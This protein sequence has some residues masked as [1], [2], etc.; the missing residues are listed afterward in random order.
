LLTRA[1]SVAAVLVTFPC[2]VAASDSVPVPRKPAA[3]E[4]ER[5]PAKEI[6]ATRSP[7]KGRSGNV[8]W[9]VV[10]AIQTRL[11]EETA[12]RWDFVVSLRTTGTGEIRLTRFEAGRGPTV[13]NQATINAPL[14]PGEDVRMVHRERA[15][16]DEERHEAFRR[17]IGRN[18][19]GN[20]VTIEV[21]IPFDQK[22]GARR[23]PAPAALVAAPPGDA[24]LPP[25]LR[26]IRPGAGVPA[27]WA[28]FS[29]VW[30]GQFDGG[31]ATVL[32][33]EEVGAR[34]ATVAYGIGPFRDRPGRW[35]RLKARPRRDQLVLHTAY[36][37][38][39]AYTR[40]GDGAL[41][42]TWT[43]EDGRSARGRLTRYTGG[44]AQP[45]DSPLA[46]AAQLTSAALA[47]LHDG[48]LADALPKAQEALAIREARL[49]GS[50]PD[51]AVSLTTLAEV[52]RA[53]G[54]LDDAE[55]LHQRA[56]SIRE[57]QL[58]REHPEVAASLNHLAVIQN[59]RGK[60]KD[61]EALLARALTV[62]DKSPAGAARA[63]RV[64]VDVL[65]TLAKVYRAQGRKR[66]AEETQARATMLWATQ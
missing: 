24:L 12:V 42:V 63:N 45:D 11:A 4:G 27:E 55:R 39:A 20:P 56:L 57:A 10:D 22:L 15:G 31:R 26:V 58:G 41:L 5:P 32:V 61:A 8:E 52:H 62:V 14:R 9:E 28:A 35:W 53:Q 25:D 17:Y 49:G 50:H 18:D 16:W 54:R 59:A 66:E 21:V 6:A 65:E 23:Q 1:L 2:V 36:N 34:D 37:E 33:V 30:T 46:R 60:Y 29:G 47:A 44:P 19:K 38:T 40:T 64:K 43:S 51:V 3:K 48:L 7:I 13:T